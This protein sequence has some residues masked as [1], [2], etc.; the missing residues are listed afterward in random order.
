MPR[1]AK[2]E[3]TVLTSAFHTDEPINDLAARL[4]MSPNTLRARWKTEFGTEAVKKRGQRCRVAGIREHK[5]DPR[6]DPVYRERDISCSGCGQPVR[7]K[8]VQIRRIDVPSFLCDAC[9]ALQ[10]DRECPVCGLK[11]DGE[12]GL[13]THFRHRREAGD[14]AHIVFHQMKEE[15]RWN[16]K[17]EGEDYVVCR[18]CGHR[19]ET[20]AR[21]LTAEHGVTAES[22][23]ATYPDAPIR[24]SKLTEKRSE[25]SRNRDGGFGKGERK[26][27]SCPG[28]GAPHIASKFVSPDAH[29][30]RCGDCLKA[31]ERARWAGKSEPDDFVECRECGWRGLNMTGHLMASHDIDKYRRDY[32]DA[33]LFADGVMCFPTHKLNLTPQD[34][35]PFK[36]SK[37][38]VQV[39]LAAD[40]FG[41]VFWTV[42]HYCKEHKL[43]TRNRL[44]FQKRVLDTV[45]G[46]VGEPY[47]W[48]WSDTRITNPVTGYRFFFDGY[49]PKHNLLVEVQGK[50]HFKFIPYWHKAQYVFEAMQARDAEK[51]KQALA[52]GFRLLTVRY[53]EPYTDPSYLRGRLA[54]MG[55]S[56]FPC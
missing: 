12:R 4:G 8:L 46:L 21:H 20:L 17:V 26:M 5:D 19:A 13:S 38:R 22:Y 43:P 14:K 49:F 6:K 11:V 42:L 37:G 31:A 47:E 48:E 15:A 40:A 23:R 32:P 53:D 35:E 50:Q 3:P 34:L 27:V 33:P 9:K 24:S 36:D 51:Q 44:A 56:L 45:A 18:I 10:Y 55:V 39:A 52:L 2:V 29:D 7:L 1:A 41:C 28:C 30:L 54:E 25:A 16:G